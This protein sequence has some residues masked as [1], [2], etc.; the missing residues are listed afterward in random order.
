MEKERPLCPICK[1]GELLDL[2]GL[3]TCCSCRK[4]WTEPEF[5]GACKEAGLKYYFK[6][7]IHGTIVIYDPKVEHHNFIEE[8]ILDAQNTKGS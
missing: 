4:M 7:S 6:G 2:C 8:V 1:V 5:L 3:I